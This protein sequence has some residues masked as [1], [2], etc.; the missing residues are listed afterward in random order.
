MIWWRVSNQP[1][2]CDNLDLTQRPL[3]IVRRWWIFACIVSLIVFLSALLFLANEAHAKPTQGDR[4]GGNPRGDASN[5]GGHHSGGG[6]SNRGSDFGKDIPSKGSQ[7]ALRNQ[8]DHGRSGGQPKDTA[9]GDANRS[10]TA[11]SDNVD[12]SRGKLADEATGPSNDPI[13][14]SG[15]ATDMATEIA[16]PIGKNAEPSVNEASPVSNQLASAPTNPVSDVA[17]AVDLPAVAASEPV[18]VTTT[19][20]AR[21]AGPALEPLAQVPLAQVR[22][23]LPAAEVFSLSGQP[24]SWSLPEQSLASQPVLLSAPISST[25]EANSI[26]IASTLVAISASLEDDL[27]LTQLPQSLPAKAVSATRGSSG[28]LSN[29]SSSAGFKSLGALALLPVLLI[30]MGG[31][32]L[33]KIRA[34]FKP[35]S[36]ILLAL[37]RPG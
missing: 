36:V 2:Q 31:K 14:T 29:S 28:G 16:K 27:S 10:N 17:G 11:R 8:G 35:S 12:N 24:L 15:G 34:S 22:D 20:T 19:A 1:N 18:V 26:P 25:K 13:T 30:L 9:V 37:D 32:H 33:C 21:A 7:G 23:S 6:D 4:G 5:N 3:V